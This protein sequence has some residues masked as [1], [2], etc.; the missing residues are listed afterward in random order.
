MVAQELGHVEVRDI[1]Q[2]NCGFG[3]VF[4]TFAFLPFLV[5]LVVHVDIA[6]TPAADGLFGLISNL[7]LQLLQML[8]VHS[9]GFIGNTDGFDRVLDSCQLAPVARTLLGLL[10]PDTQVEPQ[11][12][13][14]YQLTIYNTSSTS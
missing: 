12:G 14:H 6:V 10:G 7:L 5:L 11:M 3:I 9:N 4:H 1:L 2:R 8:D 13:S